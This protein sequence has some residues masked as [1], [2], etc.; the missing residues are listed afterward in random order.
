MEDTIPTSSSLPQEDTSLKTDLEQREEQARSLVPVASPASPESQSQKGILLEYE[1][2]LRLVDR[3]LLLRRG[4]LYRVEPLEVAVSLQRFTEVKIGDTSHDDIIPSFHSDSHIYSSICSNTVSVA[5]AASEVLRYKTL[6]RKDGFYK[7]AFSVSL[8]WILTSDSHASFI[9]KC[10]S[11]LANGRSYTTPEDF[12]N[13]LTHHASCASIAST[14]SGNE[15]RLSLVS[16]QYNYTKHPSWL[17]LI[18]THQPSGMYHRQDWLADV[19][20]APPL[21]SLTYTEVKGY[22]SDR[23][24]GKDL[25]SHAQT[26]HSELDGSCQQPSC[27]WLRSPQVMS[28]VSSRGYQTPLKLAPYYDQ[29]VSSMSTNPSSLAHTD[30]TS[31]SYTYRLLSLHIQEMNYGA[32][33][34]MVPLLTKAMLYQVTSMATPPMCKLTDAPCRYTRESNT[35][36]FRV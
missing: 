10:C 18:P 16:R 32:L 7:G 12:I 14:M 29:I 8:P 35:R 21:I 31:D 17:L 25:E 19:P 6:L 22:I 2:I 36:W 26:L 11:L 9:H 34:S 30:R 33:F 23:L 20:A 24:A 1:K 13:A 28:I 15:T 3:Q 4:S 27:V 5:F